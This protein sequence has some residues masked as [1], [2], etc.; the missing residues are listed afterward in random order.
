MLA[1][2]GLEPAPPP[3]P[4]PVDARLAP[5]HAAVADA[6][7]SADQIVRRTGLPAGAVAAAL[8]ELELAGA[9]VHSDGL[10]RE[11]MRR[12]SG[13]VVRTPLKP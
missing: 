5:V 12:D 11:V 10:Y 9:I 13:V 7:V 3:S 8:A 1:V 6:P 4:E 2:L